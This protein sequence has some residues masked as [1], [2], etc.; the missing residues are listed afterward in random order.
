MTQFKAAR[1]WSRNKILLDLEVNVK[2]ALCAIY[3]FTYFYLSVDYILK[4]NKNE[5]NSLGSV[6]NFNL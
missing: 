6:V 2:I 1:I 4:I 3:I 5:F